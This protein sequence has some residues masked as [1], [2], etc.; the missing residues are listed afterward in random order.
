MF[1]SRGVRLANA[2]EDKLKE[3]T[4]ANI[5]DT[6]TIVQWNED[7]GIRCFRLSSMVFPHFTNERLPFRPTMGYA[8][9]P[10]RELGDLANRYGHRLTTHPDHFSYTIVSESPD[11][12]R[13]AV[14]DLTLHADMLDAMGMPGDSIM[15]IHGPGTQGGDHDRVLK[16]WDVAYRSL[17]PNVRQRI[18]L[19]NTE[20]TYSVMQILHSC[21]RNG[22]PMVFDW[23]HNEVST[24]HIDI[25]DEILFRITRTWTNRGLR[26]LFHLSEQAPGQRRGAHGDLVETIPQ[27][28][29]AYP[30][31]Y[32]VG[33]D[34]EVEAKLKEQ[35]VLK[36]YQKYADKTI[37]NGKVVW[38]WK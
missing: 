34:I 28:L 1:S 12:V 13:G 10:L 29:L 2:T 6:K 20:N 33:L 7:H 26:P 5:D 8:L 22:V 4:L 38:K 14:R 3:L 35:S 23:F 17:P 25:T 37:T 15:C 31:R 27:Q 21:E 19:E 18:A 30:E 9:G 36:L 24:R 16:L 32:H 11:V